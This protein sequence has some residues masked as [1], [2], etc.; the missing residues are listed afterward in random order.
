MLSTTASIIALV[1]GTIAVW[2]A[3]TAVKFA[4]EV[5]QWVTEN[6]EKSVAL[7]KLTEIQTELTDHADSIAA[8]HKSLKTLRSR[9][10]M[11]KVREDGKDSEEPDSIKYPQEWKAW[12]RQQLAGV[13]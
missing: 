5:R 8:L 6:N 11:R 10:G 12:K 4:D 3:L 9:I 13:K 7:A 1:F 2:Y